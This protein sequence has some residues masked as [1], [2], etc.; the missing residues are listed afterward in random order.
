MGL[1]LPQSGEKPL[2]SKA[3]RPGAQQAM[4]HAAV[5]S[6]PSPPSSQGWL[7]SLGS[8][9]RSFPFLSAKGSCFR[10]AASVTPASLLERP[11][12]HHPE[13]GNEEL[14]VNKSDPSRHTVPQKRP[15]KG[16]RERR[17]GDSWGSQLPAM[18]SG[19]PFQKIHS[20]YQ[21]SVSKKLF[22]LLNKVLQ[23][24]RNMELIYIHFF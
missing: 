18:I 13:P 16:S 7:G 20:I 11:S 4:P 12:L 24:Y 9:T 19:N 21:T 3:P 5:V 15:R 22:S 2:R 1:R 23:I 8:S 6:S 10:P 17:H 14:C